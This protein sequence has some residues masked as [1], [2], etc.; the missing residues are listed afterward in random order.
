MNRDEILKKLTSV[1]RDIF[2]DESI[3]LSELTSVADIDDWDS[4]SHV[5]LISEIEGVFVCKFSTSDLSEMKNVGEMIDRI[6]EK[7]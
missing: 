6:I 7:I 1:F 5:M 4:L 2:D 3:S